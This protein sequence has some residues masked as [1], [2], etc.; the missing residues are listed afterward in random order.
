MKIKCSENTVGQLK[1]NLKIIF[2]RSIRIGKTYEGLT[3]PSNLSD[4]DAKLK[5]VLEEDGIL[6]LS[7]LDNRRF[8]FLDGD[9]AAFA[10]RIYADSIR[11][12][13]HLNEP[14]TTYS[15]EELYKRYF[16][17]PKVFLELI[18]KSMR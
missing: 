18:A 13:I 8:T 6:V 2:G 15:K 9:Y 11:T 10:N 14:A 4:G 5:A 16:R 17:I 3:A 7:T 1:Q 12:Q